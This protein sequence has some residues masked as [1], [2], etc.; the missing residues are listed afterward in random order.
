[1]DYFKLLND[2]VINSKEEFFNLL[3]PIGNNIQGKE[4]FS[5]YK[6]RVS[7]FLPNIP[8]CILENWIYRHYEFVVMNYSFLDINK[9][10]F[11]RERWSKEKIFQEIYSYDESMVNDLGYQLYQRVDK[12]WL[13]KYMLENKTWP[14]PII[15]IE[16]KEN[17]LESPVKGKLGSPYHLIEGHLRLNYFREMYRNENEEMSKHHFVWI[18]SL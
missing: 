5:S 11:Q 14:V 12:T 4:S 6:K 3:K 13:Q 18:A 10:Q 16:N 8:T 9:M 15:V 1:M 7:S 17:K 2:N